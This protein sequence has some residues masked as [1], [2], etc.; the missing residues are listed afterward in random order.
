MVWRT[1]GNPEDVHNRFIRAKLEA[2]FLFPRSSGVTEV[3]DEMDRR[4]RR[5]IEFMETG[6]SFASIAPE[7][8][9]LRSKEKE[10]SISWFERALSELQV[11]MVDSMG[12]HERMTW[13]ARWLSTR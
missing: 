9:L 7:K 3:L 8:L 1:Q 5:V 2:R 11:A 4:S 10:G 13:K 6:G 12:L